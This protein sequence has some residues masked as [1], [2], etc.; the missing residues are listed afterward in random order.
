[1]AKDSQVAVGEGAMPIPALFTYLIKTG[2]KGGVMLEYEINADN[3]IPG[4]S[5]VSITCAAFLQ[6]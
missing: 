5:R 2:Y 4:W 1:M 6:V 3:P